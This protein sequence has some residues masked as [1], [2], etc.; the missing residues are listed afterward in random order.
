MPEFPGTILGI[1]V[2]LIL[3]CATM[4]V[5]IYY[6]RRFNRLKTELA[7]VHYHA[8]PDNHQDHDHHHFDNPVYS[9]YRNTNPMSGT[10]LNNARLHNR[11]VKNINSDRE[12]AAASS[13]P[14]IS[15][16]FIEEDDISDTTSERGFGCAGN[17]FSYSS[18]HR[19]RC[20]EVDFGN[21][22]I[23]TAVNDIKD[24]REL[25]N[26]YEEIQ[27]RVA[28]KGLKSSVSTNATSKQDFPLPCQELKD[29]YQP[30]SIVK[31]RQSLSQDFERL[32]KE[33]EERTINSSTLSRDNKVIDTH[34]KASQPNINETEFCEEVMNTV[35]TLG[36]S[37]G[38]KHRESDSGVS[39][40]QST[41]TV[42]WGQEGDDSIVL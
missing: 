17:A 14:R 27:K 4:S 32:S 31:S 26:V 34:R 24:N 38:V 22:N 12:K 7:H 8:G 40:A 42:P 29:H 20:L 13:C 41:G 35:K 21:P 18:L 6:R 36:L 10:P 11:I 30:T 5:V 23:Y 3:M 1:V 2:T 9:T 19:K 28:N 33:F 15:S 16:S 39:S 25:E 37:S